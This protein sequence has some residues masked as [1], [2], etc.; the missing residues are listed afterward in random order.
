M[1]K[2]LLL[3]TITVASAFV[4]EAATQPKVF[5]LDFRKAKRESTNSLARRQNS[6]TAGISNEQI[7]YQ[8][9][10]TIG[11]PPQDFGLQ[12][13]TGS[14]DIWVPLAGSSACPDSESCLLGAFN[15]DDS[16]SLKTLP[17]APPFEISYVDNSKISGEYF[18]DTLV[19]GSTSIKRMQMGAAEESP[20]RDFGI[21]G[22]GFKSG[23]SVVQD[24]PEAAYPNIINQLKN[25]GFIKTLAYSLWLNDLGNISSYRC[26]H[27]N[28]S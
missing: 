17:D 23:E 7:F 1:S 15:A 11:T 24:D 3:F 25:Q 10:V 26:A 5:G 27:E 20:S 9:N 16:T 28:Q 18:T 2:A 14:S 12:L 21:M 22:I 6:I 8:I 13:D 4:A 19:I